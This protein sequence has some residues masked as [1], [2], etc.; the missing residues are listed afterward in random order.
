MVEISQQPSAGDLLP[1]LFFSNAL[2]QLLI[3]IATLERNVLVWMAGA[4]PLRRN[5]YQYSV[6][7]NLAQWQ[8]NEMLMVP[9]FLQPLLCGIYT[10]FIIHIDEL[11]QKGFLP[12][13]ACL[14]LT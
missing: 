10:V 14:K 8:Q 13:V 9:F 3:V 2:F 4:P 6:M 12:T 5:P 7:K 11:K 1:I